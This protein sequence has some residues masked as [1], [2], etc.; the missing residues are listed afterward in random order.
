MPNK[1]ENRHALPH[2]KYFSKDR[3]LDTRRCAFNNFTENCFLSIDIDINN[4]KNIN[5]SNKNI[6]FLLQFFEW[7]DHRVNSLNAEVAII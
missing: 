1:A 5:F 4:K 3:F 7:Q 6:N 2:E